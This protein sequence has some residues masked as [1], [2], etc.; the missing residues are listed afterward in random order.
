VVDAERL[1]ALDRRV[2]AV[3]LWWATVFSIRPLAS[4]AA[5]L[6]L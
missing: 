6:S 2:V 4:C 5:V 1:L 3:V